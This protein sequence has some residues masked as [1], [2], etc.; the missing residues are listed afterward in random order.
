MTVRLNPYLAF[1]D[2][3]A[4]AMAFYTS[5]FGG[6]LS[7]TRFGDVPMPG[8]DAGEADKVMH[9]MLEIGDGLTLMAADT[10]AHMEVPSGNHSVS[11][12]GDDE[13]RLRGWWDGLADGATVTMPLNKAPWGDT[14]GMLTDRFGIDWLVNIAG[15]PA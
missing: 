3:A 6:T 4:D 7:T 9:S 11:L 10:P 13:A 12:S 15:D 5:V 8:I 14:F 2:N 1:G